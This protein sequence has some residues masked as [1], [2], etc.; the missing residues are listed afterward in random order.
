MSAV[1]VVV[2]TPWFTTTDPDGSFRIADVP[3]GEYRL[4]VFHERA[5]A[6]QLSELSRNIT[7]PSTGSIK[8]TISENGYVS[9]PHLNKH[10]QPYAKSDDTYQL[11]K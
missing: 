9:T 5:T 11:L 7:V 10:N 3:A 2:D 6:S 4:H 8:L 1:I